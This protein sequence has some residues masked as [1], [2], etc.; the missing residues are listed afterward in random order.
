MRQCGFGS[1][2]SV[3]LNRTAVG[4]CLCVDEPAARSGSARDETGD[5]CGSGACGKRDKRAYD[6]GTSDADMRRVAFC[7]GGRNAPYGAFVGLESDLRLVRDMSVV[8]DI[9]YDDRGFIYCPG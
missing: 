2:G 7:T 8:L 6:S 3:L 5:D 9:H 4:I 1:Y